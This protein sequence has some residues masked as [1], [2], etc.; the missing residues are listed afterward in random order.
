M[1][2]WV[3]RKES[4]PIPDSYLPHM[5]HI[6][7]PDPKIARRWHFELQ[8]V[9]LIPSSHLQNHSY[10]WVPP[11][12]V[13]SANSTLQLFPVQTFWSQIILIL[14]VSLPFAWI[15]G[16]KTSFSLINLF[17]SDQPYRMLLVQEK[18]WRASR[19]LSFHVPSHQVNLPFSWITGPA[20]DPSY[21]I[22][23]LISPITNNLY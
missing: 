16:L 2:T 7:Q 6:T 8:D 21:P 20:T 9:S 11:M 5:I 23:L 1:P 10:T 15:T 14:K 19:L 4:K 17:G 22:T 18:N 12:M 13:M 3:H